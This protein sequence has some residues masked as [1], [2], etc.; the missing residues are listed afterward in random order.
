MTKE[1]AQMAI[2]PVCGMAVDEKSALY[3]SEY[4]GKVYY[5]CA[6]VCKRTFDQE[7]ARLG[8]AARKRN[9]GDS[10]AQQG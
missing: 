6:A 5:F 10:D 3:K 2:D 9:G 7:H 1:A 4:D 8:A